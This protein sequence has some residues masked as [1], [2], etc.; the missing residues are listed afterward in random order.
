MN[1]KYIVPKYMREFKCL[2][3]ECTDTCCS[4]EWKILLDKV[5]AKQYLASKNEEFRSIANECLKIIKDGSKTQYAYIG[6]GRDTLKCGFCDAEGY[7]LIHKELG[8]EALSTTCYIYPRWINEI[9]GQKELSGSLS[10]IG[11]AKLVLEE[12]NAMEL[13]E[14]EIELE[15]EKLS[16]KW[17]LN[18]KNLF[19]LK[20]HEELFW[21]IRGLIWRILSTRNYDIEERLIY[22]GVVQNTMQRHINEKKYQGLEESVAYYNKQLDLEKA[23]DFKG[24]QASPQAAV[25]L[26]TSILDIKYQQPSTQVYEKYR[27]I[28]QRMMTGLEKQDRLD[29]KTYIEV[30]KRYESQW[31][32]IET[33]LENYMLHYTF[34]NIY[35]LNVWEEN[36]IQAFDKAYMLLIINILTI[37]LHLLGQWEATGGNLTKDEVVETIQMLAKVTDHDEAYLKHIL[38]ECKRVGI[39]S[40]AWMTMLIKKY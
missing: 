25:A 11:I 22:L 34:K 24:I 35:P 4:T 10:C 32:D 39:D 9:N 16:M 26:M 20:N 37:K 31:K 15:I 8:E 29:E 17:K 19:P 33:I 30:S 18:T 40:I 14:E 7:C 36:N 13:G 1:Q 27:T 21:S 3:K 6:G 2:T 5:T 28:Y 23:L 12:D 38:K